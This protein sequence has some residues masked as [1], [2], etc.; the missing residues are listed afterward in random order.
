MPILNYSSRVPAK[1]SRAE[2]QEKLARNGAASIVIAYGDNHEVSGITFTLHADTRARYCLP[3]NVD[4]MERVLARIPRAVKTRDQA[5]RTTWRCIRD[6]VY[7]QLALI[8]AEQATMEQ[9][10]LPYLELPDG[11]TMYEAYQEHGALL[12]GP[13]AT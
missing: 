10:M 4:A 9:V 3:A 1:Q 8:E 6:W 12:L 7:A 2:I 13:A 11:R 5:T